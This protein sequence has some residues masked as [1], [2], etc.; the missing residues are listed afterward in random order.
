[1]TQPHTSGN[2]VIF[3]LAAIAALGSMAIPATV[4]PGK[5]PALTRGAG[6]GAFLTKTFLP[7]PT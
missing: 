3:T 2:A 6:G 7:T 1:M 5:R 4:F